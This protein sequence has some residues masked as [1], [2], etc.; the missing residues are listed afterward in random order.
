MNAI[1]DAQSE[2]KTKNVLMY[3]VSLVLQFYVMAK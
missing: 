3:V 2:T 1:S